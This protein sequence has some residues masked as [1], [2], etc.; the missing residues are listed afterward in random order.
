MVGNGALVNRKKRELVLAHHKLI[1]WIGNTVCFGRVQN[2]I[3]IMP[4]VSTLCPRLTYAMMKLCLRPTPTKADLPP[5]DLRRTPAPPDSYL[6]PDYDCFRSSNGNDLVRL[7]IRVCD[8][9]LTLCIRLFYVCV[10]HFMILH[11]S[12]DNVYKISTL[13]Y[14]PSSYVIRLWIANCVMSLF[15]PMSYNSCS[16]LMFSFLIA[17]TINN[18]I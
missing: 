4:A 3:P 6:R 11:V 1:L 17:P 2:I 14:T 9:G 7:P 15:L 10:H 18:L 8:T 5:I 12:I 13:V 16:Q